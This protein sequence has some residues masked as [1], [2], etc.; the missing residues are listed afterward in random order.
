M[1][2]EE[3]A[4]VQL[5]DAQLDVGVAAEIHVEEGTR[6]FSHDFHLENFD[7]ADDVEDVV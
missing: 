6:L 5:A 4:L 1:E 7:P 2:V 3:N